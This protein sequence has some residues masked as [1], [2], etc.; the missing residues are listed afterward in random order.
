[1]TNSFMLILCEKNWSPLQK[2]CFRFGSRLGFG[3]SRTSVQK[4]FSVW[5]ML[6]GH[7]NIEKKKKLE[8]PHFGS[9]SQTREAKEKKTFPLTNMRNTSTHNTHMMPLPKRILE[10]IS[11]FNGCC[12]GMWQTKNDL[13]GCVRLATG[14]HAIFCKRQLTSYPR[15]SYQKAFFIVTMTY[16]RFIA[17]N[18]HL[19]RNKLFANA[20]LKDATRVFDSARFWPFKWKMQECIKI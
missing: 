16:K 7:Y 17:R 15:A 11:D 5:R 20:C 19:A 8:I 13:C 2:S 18:N 6:T 1:M 4:P 9:M 10:L 3:S 14:N 12:V